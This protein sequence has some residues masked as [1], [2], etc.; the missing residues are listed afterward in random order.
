MADIDTLWN[1]QIMKE[2]PDSDYTVTKGVVINSTAT[3]KIS[4]K[5]GGIPTGWYGV[6]VILNNTETG[7]TYF[8][9]GGFEIRNFWVETIPISNVGGNL[10]AKW[11]QPTYPTGGEVLFG[12][13]PRDPQNP[14]IIHMPDNIEIKSVNWMVSWPPPEVPYIG[15]YSVKN[16]T[17]EMG[18][19]G[20]EIE[21]M[22]VNI[23]GLQNEGRHQAN[24]EVTV[25]FTTG[26]WR[27]GLL[28]SHQMRTFLSYSQARNSTR[29]SLTTS[30]LTARNCSGYSMKRPGCRR[31]RT[32][33]QT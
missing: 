27:T 29:A 6:D 17:V 2:I 11:E 7:E 31:K 15:V 33:Q 5:A 25:M 28:F 12:V 22:V 21:M 32:T 30:A 9:W 3:I 24:V 14:E 18:G 8:G 20:M 10:T 26:A 19:A 13:M 1:D 16:V 23:T 4:P